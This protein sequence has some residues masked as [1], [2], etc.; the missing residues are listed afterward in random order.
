MTDAEALLVATAARLRAAG[1]RDE[2]LAELVPAHRRLGIPIRAKLRPAGRAWRLGVLLLDQDGGVHATGRVTRAVPP[3]H[4]GHVAVSQEQRREVR[5]AAFRGP[6][7]V[8]ESVNYDTA[9]IDLAALDGAAGPLFA[10]DGR[11]L[12]RWS[13]SAGDD[14]ARDLEPY[15]AEQA[16]LLLHPPQGAT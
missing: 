1:A 12:V 5:D 9:R 6:F 14:A 11:P 15:L 3:G 8:G 10:R 7:A 4:P 13:V 16:E 2:A